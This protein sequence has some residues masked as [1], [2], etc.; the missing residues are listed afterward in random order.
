MRTAIVI[1]A[2]LEA[3]RLPGKPLVALGELPLVVR[4][5]RQ[6]RKVRGVDHVLVATEAPEVK[7]VVEAS[8]GV[9]VLTRADHASGTDRIAEA[10]HGL[11]ADLII[12]LQGDEPFIE[13]DDLAQVANALRTSDADLVTLRRPMTQRDELLDPSVVKVVCAD[14]GRALYFSRAPIPF[15]RTGDHRVDGTY[16]H[17]GV[18]GYRRSAL[19]RIVAAPPH[20]L[21]QREGLEQLRALALGMKIVLIDGKTH[22]RGIDTPADLEAAR[23]RVA[24]LG[25]AAFPGGHG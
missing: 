7:A 6:A 8:G 24:E 5:H 9:A 21:E 12:N 11:D 13:P 4:V 10:I 14:D 16:R 25:E 2:R 19:Q 20:P 15:D 3:T 1:P 18:Y 17:V 22:A 23:R